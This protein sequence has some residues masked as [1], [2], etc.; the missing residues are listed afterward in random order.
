MHGW[1][2]ILK[3]KGETQRRRERGEAQSTSSVAR[4]AVDVIR[5]RRP[6]GAGLGDGTAQ[7]TSPGQGESGNCEC[8]KGEKFESP[9]VVSYCRIKGEGFVFGGALMR[10][11]RFG[12]AGQERQR[13]GALQDAS[14]GSEAHGARRAYRCN[15]VPSSDAPLDDGDGAARRSLPGGLEAFRFKSRI[16]LPDGVF[17]L[18]GLTNQIRNP[19]KYAYRR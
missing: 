3:F 7:R 17:I 2:R 14:R 4:H 9:D 10:A 1:T 15:S 18:G 6:A 16:E 8:L 12:L 19:Q 5:F 11:V 13:A